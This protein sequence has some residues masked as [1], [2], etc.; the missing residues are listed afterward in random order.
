MI[1]SSMIPTYL[2]SKVIREHCT[3]ALGGDGG[4]ELFG[5]YSYFQK[6]PKIMRISNPFHHLPRLGRGFR[7]ITAPFFRKYGSPKI[8]GLLEYGSDYAGAYFSRGLARV[9]YLE[10]KKV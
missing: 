10:L 7:K 4:D 6:I 3:V 2:V 8:A 5:G 9:F 1:D